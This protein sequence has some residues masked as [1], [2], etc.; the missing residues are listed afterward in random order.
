[1]SGAELFIPLED[2][3]VERL[4]GARV[5][6]GPTIHDFLATIDPKDL[7]QA[8]LQHLGGLGGLST[9]EGFLLALKAMAEEFC[10]GS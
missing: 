4:V 9:G 10:D 6:L 8:A 2:G 1:M 3:Q 7:E 5:R